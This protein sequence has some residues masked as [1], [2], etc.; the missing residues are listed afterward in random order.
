MKK[1]LDWDECGPL[2]F[3]IA[4]ITFITYICIDSAIKEPKRVAEAKQDAEDICLIYPGSTEEQAIQ[5]ALN[6]ME[7]RANKKPINK[8]L[9]H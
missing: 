4:V 1:Y 6:I 9:S 7:L 8:R 2:M 5:S 3:L